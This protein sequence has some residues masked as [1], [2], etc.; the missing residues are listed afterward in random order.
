MI[1]LQS[2]RMENASFPTNLF[3]I[4]F[5]PTKAVAFG[6][7]EQIAQLCNSCS[8][9]TPKT[10]IMGSSTGSKNS[11]YGKSL[12]L[13][14]SPS[15][16]TPRSASKPHTIPGVNC[17]IP[18][19]RRSPLLAL[20]QRQLHSLQSDLTAWQLM[21]IGIHRRIFS[22][23]WCCALQNIWVFSN[24]PSISAVN[25]CGVLPSPFDFF[26]F[27]KKRESYGWL[28]IWINTYWDPNKYS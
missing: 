19:S 17:R 23:F 22:S 18:L 11:V 27:S 13:L 24:F 26:L 28:F 25:F 21:N 15:E 14:M 10:K 2:V 20:T 9:Y 5:R 1:I 4:S 12:S 16:R 6:K 7:G 8:V 3:C